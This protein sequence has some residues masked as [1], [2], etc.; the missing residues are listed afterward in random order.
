MPVLSEDSKSFIVAVVV[1]PPLRQAPRLTWSLNSIVLVH[2]LGGDPY[3][4]WACSRP[5]SDPFQ[6]DSPLPHDR[7]RTKRSFKQTFRRL[8][9]HRRKRA[10]GPEDG[11]TS[12]DSMASIASLEQTPNAPQTASYPEVY[13]PLDLLASEEWCKDARILVYGYDT[14]VTKG[15]AHANKTDLFGHAKNLLFDL[16]REKPPK[17]PVIFIAH[18]LGGLLVK[19]VRYRIPE[20]LFLFILTNSFCSS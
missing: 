13:W 10:V 4:T 3:K 12:R 8:W 20:V 11:V 9:P 15:Y 7:Q 5:T 2:G 14:K 16:Q 18:S 19:E 6:P 1:C 17:R